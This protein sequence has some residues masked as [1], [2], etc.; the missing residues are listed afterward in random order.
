MK[1]KKNNRLA[2]IN[3]GPKLKPRDVINIRRKFSQGKSV[4][5][6]VR[7]YNVSL[8]SIYAILE[9]KTWKNID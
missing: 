3:C 2:R 6:L 4:E 5:S 1:N 7:Q 8:G 9:R